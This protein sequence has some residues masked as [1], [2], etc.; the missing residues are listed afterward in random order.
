ML[1]LHAVMRAKMTSRVF[2]QLHAVMGATVPGGAS[3]EA[4]RRRR[5]LSRGDAAPDGTSMIVA[6]RACARSLLALGDMILL[7]HFGAQVSIAPRTP[8]RRVSRLYL[9]E[10]LKTYFIGP[11]LTL[12]VGDTHAGFSSSRRT[13][14]GGPRPLAGSGAFLAFPIDVDCH[15]SRSLTVIFVRARR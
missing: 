3:L 14:F 5:H 10:A 11:Q 4:S 1:M 9:P 12:D 6:F 8:P 2:A 13:P 7:A 15:Y